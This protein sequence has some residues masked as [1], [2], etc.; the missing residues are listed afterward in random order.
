M[1]YDVLMGKLIPTHHSLCIY[2]PFFQYETT[3]TGTVTM[4]KAL[5]ETNTAWALAVVRFGHHPHAH[6]TPTDRTNYNTL[7]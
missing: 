3:T 6:Y 5:R 2:V 1:T 4:K 7:R